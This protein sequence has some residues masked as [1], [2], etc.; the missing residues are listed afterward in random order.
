[1]TITGEVL[2]N[3]LF[4]K[5]LDKLEDT[6]ADDFSKESIYDLIR[7]LIEYTDIERLKKCYQM[8][9][10]YIENKTKRKEQKKAYR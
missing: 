10:P 3:E 4:D 6:E 5:A 8:C 7:L 9:V 2:A 1:M